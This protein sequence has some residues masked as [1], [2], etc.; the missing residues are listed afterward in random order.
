M[1]H[2]AKDADIAECIEITTN[3]TLLNEE[4]NKGLIESGLDILNISV[5]GINEKQYRETCNYN[6]KFEK[7]VKGIENFYKNK[8][9]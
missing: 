7:F 5:N 3:G 9:Q 6:I 8:E 2:Y 4:L 1:I